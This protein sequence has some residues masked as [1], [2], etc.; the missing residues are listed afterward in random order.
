[1]T[2]VSACEAALVDMQSNG[3]ERGSRSFGRLSQGEAPVGVYDIM[4]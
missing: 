1:M 3:P 2:M 4:R